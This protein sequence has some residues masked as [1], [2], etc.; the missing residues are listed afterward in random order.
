MDIR[1]D[2]GLILDGTDRTTIDH[3]THGEI[4]TGTSFGVNEE[5]L[6]NLSPTT[7]QE[8]VNFCFDAVHSAMKPEKPS[9]D[10]KRQALRASKLLWSIATAGL[11]TAPREG[12][13]LKAVAAAVEAVA[14]VTGHNILDGLDEL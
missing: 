12:T 6:S 10:E 14:E 9:F 8:L 1:E 4:S 11:R 5:G 13:A 3:L 7:A 2:G